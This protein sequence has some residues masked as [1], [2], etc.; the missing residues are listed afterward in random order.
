MITALLP[1][2]AKFANMTGAILTLSRWTVWNGTRSNETVPE[3]FVGTA[4]DAAPGSKVGE[5]PHAQ[6]AGRPANDRHVR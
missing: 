1:T 6:H 2:L 3:K 4:N 5:V